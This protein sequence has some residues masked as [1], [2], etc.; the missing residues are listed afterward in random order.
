MTATSESQF[1]TG[2]ETQTNPPG[3]VSPQPTP[4]QRRRRRCREEGERGL[5]FLPL[6]C[7]LTE[8][9]NIVNSVQAESGE[10]L[11]QT[12]RYLSVQE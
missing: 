3:S 11:D 2:E 7:G 8:F 5:T 9:P 12:T 4:K 10:P 6:V 1:S